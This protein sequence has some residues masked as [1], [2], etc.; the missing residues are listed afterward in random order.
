MPIRHDSERHGAGVRGRVLWDTAVSSVCAFEVATDRRCV[1]LA[2]GV[3]PSSKLG[4]S[5][6]A[7][8]IC[9]WQSGVCARHSRDP[10]HEERGQ[11]EACGHA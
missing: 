5:E 6:Q 8:A 7:P 3:D 11:G 2:G 10:R 1:L 9:L 4:L